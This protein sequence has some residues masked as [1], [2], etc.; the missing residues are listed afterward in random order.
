MAGAP[1]A[2]LINYQY[3]NTFTFAHCFT[4]N[5]AKALFGIHN[6]YFNSSLMLTTIWQGINRMIMTVAT[7]TKL[8]LMRT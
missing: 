6:A 1:V 3:I 5:Q 8:D 4:V 7:A 2:P